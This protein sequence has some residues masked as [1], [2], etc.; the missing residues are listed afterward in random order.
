VNPLIILLATTLPEGRVFGMDVQALISAAITLISLAVTAFFLRLILYKP[1]QKFLAARSERINDQVKSA[2]LYM[3]EA[4]GLLEQYEGQ[5]KNAEAEREKILAQANKL[6]EKQ[7]EDIIAEARREAAALKNLAESEIERERRR[8]NDEMQ[9]AIIQVA[10][11]LSKKFITL[12]IDEQVQERL[13]HEAVS[14]LDEFQWYSRG[15]TEITAHIVSAKELSESQI[16]YLRQ[17]LSEKT[18]MDVI[19]S[20]KINPAEL[21]GFSIHLDGHLIDN[22]IRRQLSEIRDGILRGI[23]NESE[24]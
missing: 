13:F 16:D 22:T 11:S 24:S 17:K 5:I 20:I 6:A 14:R 4:Q 12:S 7:G 23:D 2:E 9:R 1:L 15:N 21:G 8:I 10:A 19:L 3:A 18:G